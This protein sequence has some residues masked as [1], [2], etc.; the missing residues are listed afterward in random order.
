M[1]VKRLRYFKKLFYVAK[2]RRE[3]ERD[4]FYILVMLINT[5]YIFLY[6]EM[7]RDYSIE[8]SKINVYT[9]SN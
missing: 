9:N 5:E 6:F 7:K 1:S 2:R 3:R 8:K 4:G